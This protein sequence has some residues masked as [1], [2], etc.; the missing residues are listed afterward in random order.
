MERSADR[1]VL[2]RRAQ[3]RFDVAATASFPSARRGRLAHQIR[4]DLWRRLRDLRG[5]APVVEVTGRGPL[6]VRAGGSV[7]G[8]VP[9]GTEATIADMLTDPALRARWMSQAAPRATSPSP[10]EGEGS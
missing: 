6:T 1:L 10:S 4:Q 3:A 9:P 5:F 2:S 8:R 7:A